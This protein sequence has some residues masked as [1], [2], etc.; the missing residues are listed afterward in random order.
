MHC[1]SARS[2]SEDIE[3]TR[4]SQRISLHPKHP[5]FSGRS[6]GIGRSPPNEK[7]AIFDE[8]QRAWVATNVEIHATE[9]RPT[10]LPNVRARVSPQCHGPARGLVRN[11]LPGWRRAR[12][13]HRRS[14]HRRMAP[15]PERSLP[16]WQVHLPD[17]LSHDHNLQNFVRARD[18]HLATSIRSFRAERLSDFVGH[19]IDG[20][21][22]AAA[23]TQ[24]Q[25][26]DYPLLITR[27]LNKAR[28]WL[29]QRRRG[30]E[31][32][33]LLASSNGARLKPHGIFVKA[34][35]E[36]GKWF[37]APGDDVRSRPMLSRMQRQSSTLKVWN[38][39]GHAFAGTPT[40]EDRVGHGR[41][42]SSKEPIGR[43]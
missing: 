27:D 6:T 4:R 42:S 40:L 10:R 30:N 43:Q 16:H 11:H 37:L 18:L 31:R 13:Q 21:A 2:R 29:R 3:G 23:A 5:S 1:E 7:V 14:G 28:S 34:K 25:L 19:L 8:A 32:A 26:V 41:P 39:I 12:D 17:V 22:A 36:P 9:A 38:W 35:I 33:G 24:A 20:D 15:D